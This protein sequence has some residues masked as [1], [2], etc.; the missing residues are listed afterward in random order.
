MAFKADWILEMNVCLFFLNSDGYADKGNC[1][2]NIFRVH[3]LLHFGIW[4]YVYA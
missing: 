3:F 2:S 1:I 4:K